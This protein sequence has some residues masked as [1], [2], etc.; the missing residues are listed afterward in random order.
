MDKGGGKEG[1]GEMNTKN[2]MDAYT[3]TY[4]NI[5]PMR[6]CCMAQGTHTGAL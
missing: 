6:I 5:Q 2:S 1:E 4:V 3:P